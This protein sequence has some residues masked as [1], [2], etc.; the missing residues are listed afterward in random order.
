MLFKIICNFLLSIE[1]IIEDKQKKIIEIKWL[2]RFIQ[3]TKLIKTNFFIVFI[4]LGFLVV[5]MILSNS[6]CKLVGL[7]LTIWEKLEFLGC[8]SRWTDDCCGNTLYKKYS[9]WHTLSIGLSVR[10]LIIC[11]YRYLYI[12]VSWFHLFYQIFFFSLFS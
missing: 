3:F 6:K 12:K 9:V 5:A 2:I 11:F 8:H 1:W 10:L 4:E 7:L